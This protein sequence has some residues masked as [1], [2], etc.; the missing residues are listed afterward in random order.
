[1]AANNIFVKGVKVD[2]YEKNVYC[3]D[4]VLC[5][6]FTEFVDYN[7]EAFK[8]WLSLNP[9]VNNIYNREI[10]KVIT[11]ITCK[12]KKQKSGGG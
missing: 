7:M 10:N 5:R 3:E 12:V 4:P 9:E 1:M 2:R 8:Q 11:K 6:I